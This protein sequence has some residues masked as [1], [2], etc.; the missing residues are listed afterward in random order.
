MGCHLKDVAEVQVAS[1]TAAGDP[2][3][4]CPE[5][6]Q[7]VIQILAEVCSYQSTVFCGMYVCM[8]KGFLGPPDSS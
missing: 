7:T 1:E 2:V 3:W 6:F 4:W 5:M 8:S